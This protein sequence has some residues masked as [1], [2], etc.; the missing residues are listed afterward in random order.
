MVR[1]DIQL[2]TSKFGKR[3][4]F[5]LFHFGVD[6][7]SWTDDFKTKLPAI[8]PEECEFV[9]RKYQKKWGWSLIFKPLED[10][11]TAGYCE[12][13]YVHVEDNEEFIPGY[14]YPKGKV[15]GHT[16]VTDYMKKKDYADHL[17]FET[18]RW[19]RKLKLIKRP[20]DPEIYFKIRDISYK[21][22]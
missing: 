15:V 3:K 12:I 10:G 2:I 13:K 14:I 22:K 5:G 21:R 8:L 17:H 18:W 9:R 20:V 16:V 19:G 4:G 1:R 11:G 6:L 7:R